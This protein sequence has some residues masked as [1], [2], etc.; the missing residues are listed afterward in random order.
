M[1]LA[2]LFMQYIPSEVSTLH[3]L[4]HRVHPEERRRAGAPPDRPPR[5]GRGLDATTSVPRAGRLLRTFAA[6]V[7]LTPSRRGRRS[8]PEPSARASSAARAAARRYPSRTGGSGPSEHPVRF[9]MN[10]GP[11]GA[12]G[13]RPPPASTR[14]P[15]GGGE[16]RLTVGQPAQRVGSPD[17]PGRAGATTTRT[18]VAK[19]RTASTRCARSPQACGGDV[20]ARQ[21]EAM[22][23]S[24]SGRP[25]GAARRGDGPDHREAPRAGRR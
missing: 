11:K 12:Q 19:R 21:D 4:R 2:A 25:T 18:R 1:P 9:G 10:R 22:S 23:G 15:S 16:W 3:A 20:V 13:N 7:A 5:S 6:T 8:C 17:A 24:H 14:R